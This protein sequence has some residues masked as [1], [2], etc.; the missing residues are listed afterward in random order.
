ME[1]QSKSTWLCHG[2]TCHTRCTCIRGCF[3]FSNVDIL[4]LGGAVERSRGSSPD[5]RK[6]QIRE[7]ELVPWLELVYDGKPLSS[8]EV[9]WIVR[10]PSVDFNR[11][12]TRVGVCWGLSQTHCCC[13]MGIRC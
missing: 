2:R 9:I 1:V 11:G 8:Y 13:L 10:S 3:H 12:S 7:F 4:G 6:T 5:W